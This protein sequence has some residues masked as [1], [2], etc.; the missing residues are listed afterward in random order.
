MTSE[1]MNRKPAAAGGAKPLS[2]GRVDVKK[3]ASMAMLV[4]L[5]Y[6]VMSVTRFPL[7]AA[8]PYLR[9]DPKD[10]VLTIGAFLYGPL[11]GVAMSVTVCFL[12]LITVSEAGLW[13]FLM[14]VVASCS[15]LL[16]ASL[17]YHRRRT[18]GGAVLGLA[19]GV[20]TMTAVMLLWNYVVTPFY[21]GNPREAVAAMLLPVILPFNGV[22]ALLNAALTLVLYQP[23]N[24]ALRR[25][26][27]LP[28]L[29]DGSRRR[30]L[31][32]GILLLG[33]FL[34]ATCAALIMVLQGIL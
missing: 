2:A 24:N 34:V 26:R 17:L 19:L 28:A 6:V 4:A 10:V 30:N 8:A 9:Y 32:V 7:M 12:E 1:A 23:V 27:L 25:A 18:A 5:A 11:A 22:K 14:N 33:L 31:N 15:F 16:P 29:P 3:L 21:N 20:V 13:G